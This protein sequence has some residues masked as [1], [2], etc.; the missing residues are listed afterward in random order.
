[1][2]MIQEKEQQQGEV[3]FCAEPVLGEAARPG[4][5]PPPP[6]LEQA[7][8]GKWPSTCFPPVSPLPGD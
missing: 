3:L 8:K 7:G 6:S 5:T 2:M 4:Q 1:M